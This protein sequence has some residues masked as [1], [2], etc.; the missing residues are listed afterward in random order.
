MQRSSSKEDSLIQTWDWYCLDYPSVRRTAST[1]KELPQSVNLPATVESSPDSHHRVFPQG[2]D[3]VSWT[4]DKAP[5]LVCNGIV[6]AAQATGIPPIEES[7][8]FSGK[9][10]VSMPSLSVFDRDGKL[11]LT[12]EA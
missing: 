1:G 6:V 5:P 8:V 10:A 12:L 4:F 3:G 9:V 7:Q 11:P 2:Y